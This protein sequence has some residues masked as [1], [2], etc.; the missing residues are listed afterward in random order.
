MTEIRG[1]VVILFVL[2]IAVGAAVFAWSFHY[3]RGRRVLQLWGSE[4]AHLIR[5]NADQV[6]LLKL[7][8]AAGGGEI[9]S[10]VETSL[11][12]DGR[13]HRCAQSIDITTAP[14]L[15]HA[16]QALIEDATFD[17]AQGRGN[18]TARWEYALRFSHADR[19]ATILIDTNC[20][21]IRLHDS[22][23]EVALVSKIAK[24]LARFIDE[25]ILTTP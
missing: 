15:M 12:I 5:V 6:E 25:Q 22:G 10:D 11:T 18:C 17:W 24:G 14:G 1:K 20:Q 9:E 3:M 23:A 16:R 2:G 4:T 19:Q 21:R 13:V 8:A 7:I